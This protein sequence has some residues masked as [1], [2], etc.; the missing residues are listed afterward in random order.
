MGQQIIVQP[1]G[2]LAVFD[3]VC[4][5]FVLVDASPEE[6]T[7]WRAAEAADRARERTEAELKRVLESD[8]PY[9]QFTLTWPE[10]ERLD[11]KNRGRNG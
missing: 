11:R 5:A 4:D 7:E 9:Y 10:A 8:R 3:S 2:R 1:D 6:V